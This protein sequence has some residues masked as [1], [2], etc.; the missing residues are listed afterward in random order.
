MASIGKPLAQVALGSPAVGSPLD[1]RSKVQ[2]SV[3][4]R[5]NVRWIVV[6]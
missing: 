3:M 5:V 4:I 6:S 1:D 2:R